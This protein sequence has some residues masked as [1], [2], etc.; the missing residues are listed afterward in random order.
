MQKFVFFLSAYSPVFILL[1][2]QSKSFLI[3]LGLL[4]LAGVGLIGLWVILNWTARKPSPPFRVTSRSDAGA[5][6]AVFLAGYLLP[7][8]TANIS[9]PYTGWATAT[10]LLLACIITIRSSLIQVN[11]ILL[12]VG[13]RILAIDIAPEDELSRFTGSVYLVTRTTVRVGDVVRASRVGADVLLA[14]KNP[15]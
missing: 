11:P 8:I 1:A 13:Y 6:S 10:Y 12:L 2:V 15:K 7:L 14:A 4:S 3:Q 9:T 5:E